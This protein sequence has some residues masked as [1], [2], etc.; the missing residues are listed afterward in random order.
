MEHR[1]TEMAYSLRFRNPANQEEYFDVESLVEA[2]ALVALH[3][4]NLPRPERINRNIAGAEVRLNATN[5]ALQ[6]H[7]GGIIENWSRP[8]KNEIRDDQGIGIRNPDTGWFIKYNLAG[9]YDS[10]IALLVTNGEDRLDNLLNLRDILRR[11][12]LRGVD[13]QTNRFFHYG[14]INACIGLHPMLKPDT[15]FVVPYLTGVGSLAK[16]MDNFDF[17]IAWKQVTTDIQSISGAEAQGYTDSQNDLHQP[18]HHR[19][20]GQS[21]HSGGLVTFESQSCF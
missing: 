8:T 5:D 2:M 13:I 20:S 12:E 3:G 16:E 14:V 18:P 7:A 21:P 9:A 6:P 15:G 1:V 4:K 17:D 10:N 11:T 19:A